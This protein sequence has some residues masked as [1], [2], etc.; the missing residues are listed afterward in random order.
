[1]E[2]LENSCNKTKDE[3]RKFYLCD[4]VQNRTLTKLKKNMKFR[5]FRI[6]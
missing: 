1:M 5:G 4:T 2:K 6:I 3:K